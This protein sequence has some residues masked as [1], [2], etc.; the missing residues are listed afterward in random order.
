MNK[1]LYVG[2]RNCIVTDPH[3]PRWPEDSS[4]QIPPSVSVKG[5][6]HTQEVRP[7]AGM[8][9]G[10]PYPTWPEHGSLQTGSRLLFIPC[11]YFPDESCFQDT[12]YREMLCQLL[13]QSQ[14]FCASLPFL[15]F[16]VKILQKKVPSLLGTPAF[17]FAPSRS[18]PS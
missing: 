9:M 6:C 8:L 7:S 3:H 2:R 18:H 10:C 17:G 15:S 5:K 11:C 1:N 16:P 14:L 12:T 4:G 13:G